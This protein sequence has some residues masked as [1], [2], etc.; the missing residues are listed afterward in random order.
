MIQKGV[1]PDASAVK[2][3]W[4]EDVEAVIARATL[5][6][7]EDDWMPSGGRSGQ[8]TE[9]LAYLLAEMQVLPRTYPDAK[10]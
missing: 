4:L 7:P 8:H 10:W 3:E 6:L 1:L 9:H 2:A 5:T